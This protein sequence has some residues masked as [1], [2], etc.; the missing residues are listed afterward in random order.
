MHPYSLDIKKN[1]RRNVIICIVFFTLVTYSTFQKIG[2]I[3]CLEHLEEKLDF[4]THGFISIMITPMVIYSSYHYL[5]NNFIWKWKF[6]NKIIKV[7]NING[8]YEGELQS[9]YKI[10][11]SEELPSPIKM[12]LTVKQNLDSI[13]FISE[14][15]DTPSSSKSNMGALMLYKDYTAEFI[16][17]YSSRSE[18]IKI[19]HDPHDG[20]NTLSFNLLNGFIKGVYFNG[21]GKNPNKGII[22]LEKKN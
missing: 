18:D 16:F 4:V 10:E 1:T 21:R 14:Y 7:P 20:M 15:P 19:E 17:A 2:V 3:S 12:T 11:N 5:F 8:N 22:N 9:S 13:T 6:V